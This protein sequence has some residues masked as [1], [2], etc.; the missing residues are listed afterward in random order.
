MAN[1]K[2]QFCPSILLQTFGREHRGNDYRINIIISV[3]LEKL[4]MNDPNE[5]KQESKIG[6]NSD[7]NFEPIPSDFTTLRLTELPGVGSGTVSNWLLDLVVGNHDLQ[8]LAE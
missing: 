1:Q 5:K 7:I 4:Y 3:A 2:N 6:W 8:V